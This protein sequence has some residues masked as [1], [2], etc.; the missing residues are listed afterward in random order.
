MLTDQ[1]LQSRHHPVHQSHRRSGQGCGSSNAETWQ[2]VGFPPARTPPA[3]GPGM[4][5]GES[6]RGKAGGQQQSCLLWEEKKAWEWYWWV[7]RSCWGLP[8]PNMGGHVGGD[9]G[10]LS[11]ERPCLFAEEYEVLKT[12]A[13]RG[14]VFLGQGG[15]RP[16][17]VKEAN[18]P[19]RQGGRRDSR[20]SSEIFPEWNYLDISN[21]IWG[22]GHLWVTTL[23]LRKY[24]WAALPQ[25]YET[26]S[27]K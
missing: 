5:N 1:K 23:A 11:A 9:Y 3:W 17:D 21:K 25:P 15:W 24:D 2:T 12:K 27:F 4:D 22:D 13:A 20:S 8:N 18:M 26:L 10:P 19:R 16:G 14:G 7:S 6:K